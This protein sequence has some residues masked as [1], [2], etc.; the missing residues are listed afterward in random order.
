M[1]LP[2]V[3]GA[4]SILPTGQLRTLK[5]LIFQCYVTKDEEKPYWNRKTRKSINILG[6]MGY[7][8]RIYALEADSKG[9]RHDNMGGFHLHF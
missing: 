3:S 7:S 4:T 6:V 5:M 1:V 8:H 2:D 9:S